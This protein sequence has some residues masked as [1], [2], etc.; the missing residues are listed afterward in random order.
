MDKAILVIDMPNCCNECFALDD[1]GNYYTCLITQEQKGFRF[2]AREQKM[3]K[4][5]LKPIPEKVDIPDYDNTIKAESANAFEVGMYMYD[6]GHYRGYNLCI[7][8][9]LRE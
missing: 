5:P 3:D 8:N 4:C 7:D 9:I 2:K 6:R 1:N